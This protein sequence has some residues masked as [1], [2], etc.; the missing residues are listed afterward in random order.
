MLTVLNIY[1]KQ[2][3][4]FLQEKLKSFLQCPFSLC[5]VSMNSRA[6]TCLGIGCNHISFRL[7]WPER[8]WLEQYYEVFW[9]DN[10][11][12][13]VAGCLHIFL[14]Q[15]YHLVLKK[16]RGSFSY[17]DDLPQIQVFGLE[18]CIRHSGL[19][20]LVPIKAAREVLIFYVLAAANHLSFTMNHLEISV[21]T[22]GRC[23]DICWCYSSIS[24]SKPDWEV[25]F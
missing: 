25:A 13:L 4:Q 8:K 9:V 11:F 24:C 16:E 19:T 23:T 14:Q 12:H 18:T 3:F 21:P 15:H 2:L 22:L 7:P 20:S 6:L 10:A 1:S 17:W 5:V